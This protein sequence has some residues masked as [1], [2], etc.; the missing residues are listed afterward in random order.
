MEFLRELQRT[1]NCGELR[2][3]H[4]GQEVV[5]MGWVQNRRDMGAC[6]FVVLRDRYGL[7]QL[8]FDQNAEPEAFGIGSQVRNEYV[9]AVRGVVEDRGENRN[10]NMPTGEI[11]VL[12]KQIQIF[13][14]AQLPPFHIRDDIDTAEELKL[15]YRF[16]DLRRAPLQQKLILRSQVNQIVRRS[17]S[18]RGFLEIETPVLANTSPEGARDYL[19]P[20]RI[21]PGCFYALPQSPQLFKQLLMVSGFDR[22]FQICHC[23]R[24]EDLRADRQPEFT[25]IDMEMSFT[26]PEIIQD[27]V[28]HMLGAVFKEAKG[29][30][31]PAK[32]PHITWHDAMNRYGSDK[33]DVR[34]GLEFVD[35]TEEGKSSGFSVFHDTANN[36][37]VIKAIVL[38][39][40]EASKGDFGRGRLDKLTS[41]C[42]LYGAKGMAWLKVKD[43]GSW[44][45]P[46]GKFISD[47]EHATLTAK[48]GVKPGSV[49]FI[50]ADNFTTTC[51]A[52]G[53]LRLQLGRDLGLIDNS[54]YAFLWVT[55]FPMFEYDQEAGRWFAMHHPFT[56]PRPD[57]LDRLESDPGSVLA[58]AYDV[59][60]N[61][62]E[63]GGG[64][65]RIHDQSVQKR[66]FKLLGLTEEESRTRFGFLLDALTYGT[67]PHGGLA[68]GMDRLMMLLTG[69]D[70]I[71]DV[72]AFPKTT[73]ASC[74]MTGAPSVANP[75]Q[76]IEANIALIQPPEPENRDA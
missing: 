52:L 16:L 44:Q 65:I 31:I 5:L 20:S 48:L 37:G 63:L 11:E 6:I 10:P 42:K 25:Q 3:A 1:H 23:F 66:V 7:T 68:I 38:S 43:D 28:E 14:A 32:F 53:A 41:L 58:Q 54:K 59:V 45:A 34:F 62:Y 26:T 50:V 76:L 13:N 51:A 15:R 71:R 24:D 67:P 17:L 4:I 12:V 40:E 64:S 69:T 56:S 36:G 29:V 57:D 2:A 72:I 73:S 49:A 22:Y 21:H 30:D 8:K 60:L 9:V 27:V 75:Q 18:E 74:L 47:A 46:F 35:L 55:D 33:P 61:G 19:V 70:N 39:P